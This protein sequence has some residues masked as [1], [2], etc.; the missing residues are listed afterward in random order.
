MYLGSPLRQWNPSGKYQQ[1]QQVYEWSRDQAKQVI[2]LAVSHH[3]EKQNYWWEGVWSMRVRE[4]KT[5]SRAMIHEAGLPKSPAWE[6]AQYSGHSKESKA[7][8]SLVQLAPPCA[9]VMPLAAVIPNSSLRALLLP[10]LSF[11]WE[12][13]SSASFGFKELGA[14]QTVPGK[15]GFLVRL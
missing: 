15:E 9:L 12:Y 5:S 2:H 10:F 1:E 3:L 11:P 4:R 7:V 14:V 13:A 8:R 6:A